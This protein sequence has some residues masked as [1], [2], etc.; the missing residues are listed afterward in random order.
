MILDT[1][2][3]IWFHRGDDEAEEAISAIPVES[4]FASIITYME[5]MQGVRNNRELKSLKETI[6]AAGISLLPVNEDIS[7]IAR[8]YLEKYK[9]KS[10]FGIYDALIGAPPS[11]I[12]KLFLLA[13]SSISKK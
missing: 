13:I 5:M 7:W 8:D 3:L 11:I 12:K 9:L 10:G 4:R 1:D 2:I 6:A